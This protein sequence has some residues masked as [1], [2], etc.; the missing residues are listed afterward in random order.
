M[1]YTI[2]NSIHFNYYENTIWSS[3]TNEEDVTFRMRIPRFSSEILAL[4]IAHNGKALSREFMLLE[5]WESRALNSSSNNLNNYV[6]ILRRKLS[7]LGEDKL[8]ITIP[9]YGFS[10]SA[11]SIQVIASE[12][13]LEDKNANDPP[14]SEREHNISNSEKYSLPHSDDAKVEER[15]SAKNN[16]SDSSSIFKRKFYKPAASLSAKKTSIT[17]MLFIFF[18]FF[19]LRGTLIAD[20]PPMDE[21]KK[22]GLCTVFTINESTKEMT[23]SDLIKRAEVIV[24]ENKIDCSESAKI[25]FSINIRSDVSGG[26]LKEDTLSYCPDAVHPYCENFYYSV[27]KNEK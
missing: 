19:L 1:I 6:S 26:R 16:N 15:N 2:N 4:F 13:Q 9:K 18:Y 5:V 21:I 3:K 23:K 11:T 25:Y 20:A 14:E 27:L 7:H 24:S 12:A 10:F 8:I 22:L 17:V